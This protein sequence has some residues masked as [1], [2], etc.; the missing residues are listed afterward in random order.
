M[1]MRQDELMLRDPDGVSAQV[2]EDAETLVDHLRACVQAGPLPAAQH[3]AALKWSDRRIRAAAEAS[4]GRVLSAPGCIGYRLA[5]HT[6]VAEYYAVERARFKS[7][8][9]RMTRRLVAM[10]RA[11][12]AASARRVLS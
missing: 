8:I 6:S 2:R 10:D 1:N 11:V 12:H 4:G 5:E 7:Q 9:E 3:A